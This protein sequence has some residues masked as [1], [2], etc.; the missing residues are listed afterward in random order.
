MESLKIFHFVLEVP[1]APSRLAT[2]IDINKVNKYKHERDLS[3]LSSVCYT[4]HSS[5]WEVMILRSLLSTVDQ[6]RCVCWLIWCWVFSNPCLNIPG[7]RG[8]VFQRPPP[9]TEGWDSSDLDTAQ[10]VGG[11]MCGD[12]YWYSIVFP[13]YR[14]K[15]WWVNNNSPWRPVVACLPSNGPRRGTSVVG[16]ALHSHLQLTRPTSNLLSRR[17]GLDLGHQ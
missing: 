5:L 12:K 17:D 16:S 3:R 11:G 8:T 14:F 4:L 13:K 1:P 9:P 6:S 2:L 10:E 7:R 15:P